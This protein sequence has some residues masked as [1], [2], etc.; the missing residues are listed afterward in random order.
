MVYCKAQKVFACQNPIFQ[1]LDGV[2]SKLRPSFI[3]KSLQVIC[4]SRFKGQVGL[5]RPILWSEVDTSHICSPK[6]IDYQRTQNP[7]VIATPPDVVPETAASLEP[8]SGGF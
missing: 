5:L 1:S 4:F 7:I 8:R 2:V 3:M 6:V